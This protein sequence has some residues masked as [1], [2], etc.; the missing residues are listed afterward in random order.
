MSAGACGSEVATSERCEHRTQSSCL[1]RAAVSNFNALDPCVNTGALIAT[2]GNSAS[3]PN[4]AKVQALCAS[5][6]PARPPRN[7]VAP[8][9]GSGVAVLLGS[10]EGNPNLKPEVADTITAG[11]RLQP[12]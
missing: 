10:L 9:R 4:Q 6:V 5:I 1:A 2:Y 11:R 3:N 7:F 12:G 8:Y